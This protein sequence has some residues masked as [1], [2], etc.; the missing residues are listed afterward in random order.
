M[1]EACEKINERFAK[2]ITR[3]IP[4]VAVKVAQ[5][6]DGK[7]SGG[8]GDPRWITTL[9]L[10]SAKNLSQTSRS[11]SV[12]RERSNPLSMSTGSQRRETI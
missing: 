9:S 10:E 4:F 2:F 5:S 6:L 12:K 3:N 11:Q 8:P 7:I 1:R